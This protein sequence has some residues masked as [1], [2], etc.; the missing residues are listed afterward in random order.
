MR[1]IP[2]KAVARTLPLCVRGGGGGGGLGVPEFFQLNGFYLILQR[3]SRPSQVAYLESFL[4]TIST[5]S[6]A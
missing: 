3:P 5:F 2:F 1:V 6:T 4:S